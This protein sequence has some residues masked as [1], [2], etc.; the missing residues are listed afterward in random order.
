MCV[1]ECI[2][3]CPSRFVE[4]QNV[5]LNEMIKMT[6]YYSK[7]TWNYEG[8]LISL[9]QMTSLQPTLQNAIWMV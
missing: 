3:M 8:V 6:T 4:L 9:I 1:C 5:V 7:N 2:S